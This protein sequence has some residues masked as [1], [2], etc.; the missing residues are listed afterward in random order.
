MSNNFISRVKCIILVCVAFGVA[1]E[2]SAI[3][4]TRRSGAIVFTDPTSA[5]QCSYAAYAI[6]NDAAA[7]YSNIWVKVDSFT[8]TVVRLAG[9]DPGL[10]ALDD[11]PAGQTK[12]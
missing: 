6:S 7:N 4:I 10:Y 8:G 3:T 12:M 9:G 2:A 11:L 1:S 5:L